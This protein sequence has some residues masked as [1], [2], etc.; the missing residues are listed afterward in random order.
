M[1]GTFVQR[2]QKQNTFC[3]N[4]RLMV[5]AGVVQH[6]ADWVDNGCNEL[7]NPPKRYRGVDVG[8]LSQL[9]RFDDPQRMREAHRDW[10]EAANLM[11]SSARK[12]LIIGAQ[13]AICP[14][15][16][17]HQAFDLLQKDSP[18]PLLH[19]AEEVGRESKD[20]GFSMLAITGTKYL[21]TGPVYPETLKGL[22]IVC[23]VPD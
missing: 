15:N 16:T 3:T 23:Q 7:Q 14:D 9:L 2:M 8:Q 1:Y 22:G 12:L 19:I 18:I 21:T 6:P 5:R 10:V 11:L 20:R 17:I 4:V 13:I